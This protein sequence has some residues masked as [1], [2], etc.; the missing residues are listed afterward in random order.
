[1][2]ILE[3][4]KTI[5]DYFPEKAV[6]LSETMGLLRDTLEETRKE[7]GKHIML[8]FD[9]G[10]HE[11][12]EPHNNLAASI[13][14]YMARV[15]EIQASL[16]PDEHIPVTEEEEN[17]DIPNYND[18][19]IDPEAAHNLHEDFTYKRPAA[20]VLNEQRIE[21]KTWQQMLVK[22]SEIL[23]TLDS[24]R[25]ALFDN[26]P[27][28]MGRKQKLFSSDPAKIRSPYKLKDSNLYVET[29]LSANAIRNLIARMLRRFDIKITEYKVFLR[30]DYSG[31]HE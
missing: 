18:Y 22:T 26:D 23:M 5:K 13:L 21:V 20:F 16:E 15:Q 1:M 14:E 25:F 29:N 6:D 9:Q 24:V 2:E 12:I 7:I 8:L 28:M 27:G 11:A 3:I 4:T 19:L 17:R 10:K 30:A 31:L